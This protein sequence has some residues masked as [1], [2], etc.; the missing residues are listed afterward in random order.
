MMMRRPRSTKG[1]QPVATSLRSEGVAPAA[2]SSKEAPA[3]LIPG[4]RDPQ[5]RAP[6]GAASSPPALRPAVPVRHL[7][8]G[9]QTRR[10]G[11]RK[12]KAGEATAGAHSGA[13]KIIGRHSNERPPPLRGTGTWKEMKTRTGCGRENENSFPLSPRRRGSRSRVMRADETRWLLPDLGPRLRGE[14]GEEAAATPRRPHPP[15]ETGAKTD[16]GSAQS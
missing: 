15:D 13:H 4:R 5:S 9:G 8:G 2:A 3:G 10:F 12:R 16:A 14:S 6:A 11:E 1:R 7:K